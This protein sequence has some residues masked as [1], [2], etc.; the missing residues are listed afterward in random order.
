[1]K[2]NKQTSD[3]LSNKDYL[4][5]QLKEST[6]KKTSWSNTNDKAKDKTNKQKTDEQLLQEALD[7]GGTFKLDGGVM[8]IEPMQKKKSMKNKPN[9]PINNLSGVSEHKMME[10]KLNVEFNK[11]KTDWVV[12]FDEEVIDYFWNKPTICGTQR[13][14]LNHIEKIKDFITKTLQQQ[15][16]DLIKEIE[17]I[18]GEDE[19]YDVGFYSTG[20]AETLIIQIRNQLRKQI[21]ERLKQITNSKSK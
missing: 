5:K 2:P 4:K 13:L 1:M 15:K 14:S 3:I 16:K 7:K 10:A 19:K 8:I 11:Q 20:C 12:E 6:Y 17:G 9:K 21:R 18:V